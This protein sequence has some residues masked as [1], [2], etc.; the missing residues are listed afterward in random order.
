MTADRTGMNNTP[1]PPAGKTS[2]AQGTGIPFADRPALRRRMRRLRRQLNETEQRHAAQNLA[3]H[4]R[5]SA[6]FQ[7]SRHIGFYLAN[8]GE[9][10]LSPLL[11]HASGMRKACYLPLITP[12]KRLRFAPFQP[13]DALAPNAFGIPEPAGAGLQ[14][15]DAKFLDLLLMP[16]VAFDAQGNRLGMG[17]GFYDRSLAFLRQ[18]HHWRKPRLLGI[19]HAFQ[20]VDGLAA[21]N[22]DVPL[23][24]IAT[25]Q[26][27]YSP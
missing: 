2:T 10:D 26:G 27:L 6:L 9:L 5:R 8:D 17:G 16:L 20:R 22:W 24:A 4:V 25:D 7:R 11:L 15:V 13:G 23:D 3:R 12:D 14:L 19:A 21:Q 1:P 18:R